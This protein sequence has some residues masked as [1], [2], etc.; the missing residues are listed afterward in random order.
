MNNLISIIKSF[1]DGSIFTDA[2][3]EEQREYRK[4]HCLNKYDDDDWRDDLFW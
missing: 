1:C 2:I 3:R 4:N